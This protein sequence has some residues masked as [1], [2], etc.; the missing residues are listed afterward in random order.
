LLPDIAGL[1]PFDI[2]PNLHAGAAKKGG[3]FSC[4]FSILAGMA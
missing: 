1:Q 2:K 4:R 3:Q